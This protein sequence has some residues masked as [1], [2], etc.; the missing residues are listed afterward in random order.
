MKWVKSVLY[1]GSLATVILLGCL[2]ILNDDHYIAIVVLVT[3][4]ISLELIWRIFQ[5]AVVKVKGNKLIITLPLFRIK[6]Y[7]LQDI[8]YLESR[9]WGEFSVHFKQTNC[10]R[11]YRPLFFNP[12]SLVKIAKA[13]RIPLFRE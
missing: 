9:E 1:Y 8:S 10:C 3:S 13:N 2:F 4:V 7:N 6:K 12:D 5:P 11:T